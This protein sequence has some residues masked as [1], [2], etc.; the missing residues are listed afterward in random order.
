MKTVKLMRNDFAVFILTHGRAEKQITLETLFRCGYSGKTYLI[1]DD[2][3]S[4]K[5]AYHEKYGDMVIEF[6]KREIELYFD[7]MVNWKEY[8]SVVYARNAAYFIAKRLGIRYFMTCDDDIGNLTY[9]VVNENKL[10]GFNVRNLDRLL[11]GMVEYMETAGIAVFGFSQSGAYIGGANGSKYKKGCQRMLSQAMIFDAE[12]RVNIRG[13][14]NE[15]FNFSADA[16]ICGQVALATMLVSIQSPERMSNTGGLFDL[17]RDNNTYV[18]DF[19]SKMANPQ[20][21]TLVQDG[22]DIK[23]HVVGKSFA[24]EIVSGRYQKERVA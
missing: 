22:Y 1:I 17:Y 2:E 11:I 24:P 8:R 13:I 15:D 9:R 23:L 21:C 10:K 3:D 4:Q 14:F 16:G 19:F 5:E 20:A 6:S 18:R 7:T 12:N